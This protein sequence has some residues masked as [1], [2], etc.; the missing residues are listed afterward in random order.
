[1]Y[2]VHL[3][4][5]SCPWESFLFLKRVCFPDPFFSYFDATLIFNPIFP[6]KHIL[7]SPD[8]DLECQ[9]QKKCLGFTTGWDSKVQLKADKQCMDSIMGLEDTWTALN[10]YFLHR[11]PKEEERVV[12][13]QK[14]SIPDK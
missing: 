13:A 10:F 12:S 3:P 9:C 8:K 7:R 1:M 6:P 11:D 2:L 5:T 4:L 14:C